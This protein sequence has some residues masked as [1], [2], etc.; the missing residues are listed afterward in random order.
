MAD[1]ERHHRRH[2]RRRETRSNFAAP[3]RT[4]SHQRPR[5]LSHIHPLYLE[6]N[7]GGG[8]GRYANVSVLEPVMRIE[9]SG[10]QSCHGDPHAKPVYRI[11]VN[12]QLQFNIN[13]VGEELQ[14]HN[15]IFDSV[16]VRYLYRSGERHDLVPKG[17]QVASDI[18]IRNENGQT[19][20]VQAGVTATVAGQ[21]MPAFTVHAQ[22]ASKLTYERK[23]R[24]WRKSLTYETYPQPKIETKEAGLASLLGIGSPV[25]PSPE[26]QFRVSS[27][28]AHKC[29]CRKPR[30][31][32]MRSS[33]QH[34]Y[35]RAAH[36]S[37]QTEAQLHLWTP[38]I[39][40]SM[41]CP[42]T[43]TREVD[44]ELIDHIL[45]QDPSY[46]HYELRRY[47]HFDFDVEVRLR[48]IGRGFWGMFKSASQPAEI[49]ARND[50]GRP[51][52][53][54]RS[55]F[56]VTCCIERINWP[57][58]ETRDLQCEAEEQMARF[59]FVKRLQSTE[60]YQN[61]ANQGAT[62]FTTAPAQAPTYIQG[63]AAAAAT[64][65]AAAE[66]GL[67]TETPRG[68]IRALTRTPSDSQSN[69]QACRRVSFS[70]DYHLRTF[71]RRRQPAAGSRHARSRTP[72]P[73]PTQSVASGYFS[74]RDGTTTAPPSSFY[75]YYPSATSAAS[76]SQFSHGQARSWTTAT[77]RSRG[78]SMTNTAQDHFPQR[79]PHDNRTTTTT[80]IAR[81][82]AVMLPPE[83]QH[84][85]PP[86][87]PQPVGGGAFYYHDS[88]QQH[89]YHKRSQRAAAPSVSRSRESGYVSGGVDDDDGDEGKGRDDGCGGVRSGGSG[90][91]SRAASSL[92]S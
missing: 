19:S 61:T 72:S 55:K 57:Q 16:H 34:V 4:G 32:R 89:Y 11:V 7:V 37:G 35:N 6:E 38:E 40:E 68:R 44:A 82:D 60:E 18:Q 1:S 64:I 63:A 21:P 3:P 43:V 59:G 27:T 49:R 5:V 26:A 81:S 14:R 56:C 85:P 66:P 88:P 92:P 31:C 83:M 62:S 91:L 65:A 46:G 29:A 30:R 13:Q 24:S 12:F 54:D 25:P 10:P 53:P 48:E 77:G 76:R 74:H 86:P 50:S 67:Q 80:D 8:R 71:G 79:L 20:D 17:D 45:S 69:I 42:I 47:L 39:Y 41:N 52:P 51:L 70:P 75:P 23:L 22:H 9:R 15:R 58:H 73:A 28:H 84:P 36:W 90:S 78:Q 87:P 2:S 33:S